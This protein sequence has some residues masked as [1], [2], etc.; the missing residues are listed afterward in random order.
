MYEMNIK[1]KKI[2]PHHHPHDRNRIIPQS[3]M[4]NVIIEKSI[5]TIPIKPVSHVPNR[6]KA[7]LKKICV[8]RMRMKS[9]NT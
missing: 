9:T 6:G 4:A 2:I 5:K 7:P 3:T 8:N 1:E